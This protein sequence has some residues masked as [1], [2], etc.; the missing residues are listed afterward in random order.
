MRNKSN[1]EGGPAT[2]LVQLIQRIGYNDFDRI[3]LATVT[4]PP[5]SLRIKVDNMKIEL[6][7]DDLVVAQA[8]TNHSQTIRRIDGTA[9]VITMENELKA[10]DRVLVVSMNNGQAYAV[11][12]RAVF[13][14]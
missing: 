6:D 3:E 10:G 13:Y 7:A 2:Q 8:L 1:I 11:L 9:E 14:G 5:P 12:D 4:S